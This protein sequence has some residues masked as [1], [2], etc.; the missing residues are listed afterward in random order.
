M[1]VATVRALKMHGGVARS[2]LGTPD[3]AAVRRG[4]ANL[5]RHVRNMQGFGL[6]VCVCLNH[7]TG[8]TDDE[9]DAV[10]D[11]L[12]PLDVAVEVC[13]H[14]AEGAAG[15]TGLAR[16]VLGLLE[17]GTARFAPLYADDLP[18]AEKLRTVARRIYGAADVSLPAA[19]ARR[20]SAFEAAGHGHLPVC[21][22]KT[23][24]SFSAD[25]TLLGAP[26]GHVLPVREVR[27]SAGAGFVVAVCGDVMTMPGLPR[28]PAAER[29]GL[30]ADGRVDGLF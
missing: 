4:C 25:P 20:L 22:A 12:R 13:R 29:I 18:L 7:F 24:Y 8:D 5:L 27:L 9:L 15:A 30:D 10:R 21:I 26:E 6:P 11:A 23:Q 2:A 16:A 14:W 28:H 17:G 1:V 3:V 19:V